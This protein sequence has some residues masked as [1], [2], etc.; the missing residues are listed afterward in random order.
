[1]GSITYYHQIKVEEHETWH[2]P[3]EEF[4]GISMR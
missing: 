4:S 2:Q 3:K 1:M